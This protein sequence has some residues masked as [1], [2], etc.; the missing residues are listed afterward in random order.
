MTHATARGLSFLLTAE[1]G[2]GVVAVSDDAIQVTTKYSLNGN[3]LMTVTVHEDDAM[4]QHEIFDRVFRLLVGV[5]NLD[6]H[7]TTWVEAFAGLYRDTQLAVDSDG[8]RY[9]VLYVVHPNEVLSRYVSGY[10]KGEPNLSTWTATV[11]HTVLSEVVTANAT[12][13]ATVANGR[14]RD[15][16]VV[17]NFSVG[18][19]AGSSTAIDFAVEPGTGLLDVVR[20]LAKVAGLAF[21]V[22]FDGQDLEFLTD[23]LGGSRAADLGADKS[24]AVHFSTALDNLLGGSLSGGELNEKTVA[25]V[26]GAGEGTSRTFEVRTGPNFSAGVNESEMWVN[27][28][29]N[30]DDELPSIGDAALSRVKATKLVNTRTGTS[31]AGFPFVDYVVGDLVRVHIGGQSVVKQISSMSIT[32]DQTQRVMIEVETEDRLEDNT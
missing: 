25:I 9:H 28:S 10:P 2:S 30:S 17:N 5:P 31:G 32:F 26:G 16:S 29:T 6:S 4:A 8:V 15:S 1:T 20:S 23:A 14:V 11:P 27:A 7:G 24:N 21:K 3:G 19:A 18:L 13:A 22:V 12:A